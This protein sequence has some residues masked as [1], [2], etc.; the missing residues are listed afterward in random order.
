MWNCEQF[1]NLHVGL[2]LDLVFEHLFRFSI[3][4]FFCVS[5]DHFIPVLPD[6]V[7]FS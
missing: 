1:L 4:V 3:F 2:G 5:L 6:F 7:V